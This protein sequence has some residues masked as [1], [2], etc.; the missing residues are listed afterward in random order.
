MV[1][2]YCIRNWTTASPAASQASSVSPDDLFGPMFAPRSGVYPIQGQYS[3][4]SALQDQGGRGFPI[5]SGYFPSNFGALWSQ[6][7]GQVRQP[8]QYSVQQVQLTSSRR[9]EQRRGRIPARLAWREELGQPALEPPSPADGFPSRPSRSRG[10]R[11]SAGLAVCS[12]VSSPA[13]SSERGDEDQVSSGHVSPGRSLEASGP[14]GTEVGSEG[15]SS[16]S[17][18]SAAESGEISPS[19]SV[20]RLP[21][22]DPLP[23]EP[24]PEDHP[25]F[26]CEVDGML[27]GDRH[28]L[29]Q[30]FLGFYTEST[31]RS[32]VAKFA[33]FQTFCEDP[34]SGRPSRE[35]GNHLPVFAFP[36]RGGTSGSSQPPS[37][38]R[39]DLNGPPFDGPLAV[40][41]F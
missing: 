33:R 14:S 39:G 1:V 5:G 13:A 35:T 8:V 40:F 37:V 16:A 24:M 18:P 2:M 29:Q 21:P 27:A 26:G 20:R 23:V 17:T 10:R 36:A 12:V 15:V 30:Q 11:P 7:V 38:P 31:R 9:G 6:D 4:G 34:R 32:M 41:G 28:W 22:G 25:L 3:A 19:P